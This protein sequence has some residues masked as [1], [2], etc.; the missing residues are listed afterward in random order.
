LLP[1]W[2]ATIIH[3][4]QQQK[5]FERNLLNKNKTFGYAKYTPK[6]E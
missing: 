4:I 5:L 1:V 6:D 2:Y 3:E